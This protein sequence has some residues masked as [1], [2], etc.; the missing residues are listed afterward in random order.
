VSPKHTS[1]SE[2]AGA[3]TVVFSGILVR[4]TSSTWSAVKHT[5]CLN[6]LF[7]LNASEKRYEN[8]K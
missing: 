8:I 6:S 2:E 4:S 7:K 1:S 3:E 5:I